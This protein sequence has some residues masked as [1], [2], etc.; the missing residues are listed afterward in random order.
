MVKNVDFKFCM[1]NFNPLPST[2]YDWNSTSDQ[3]EQRNYSE[4]FYI[5]LIYIGHFPALKGI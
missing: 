4:M 5:P 2:I 3:N 1:K